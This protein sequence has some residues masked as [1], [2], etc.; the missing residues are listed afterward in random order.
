MDL[1]KEFLDKKETH[2]LGD[3]KVKIR[4][5]TPAL[6]KDLTESMDILPGILFDAFLQFHTTQD[7]KDVFAYILAGT[8]VVTDELVKVTSKLSE[9]DEDYLMNKAG[10]SEMINY[11]YKTVKKNNLDDAIKNLLSPLMNQLT[12]REKA[13]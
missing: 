3:K 4:K 8:S 5:I 1:L 10:L 7:K 13:Q 12:N 11:L 9:L 2:Q 6:Y